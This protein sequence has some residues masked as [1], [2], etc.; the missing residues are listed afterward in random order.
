MGRSVDDIE[1]IDLSEAVRRRPAMYLGSID[2]DETMS[3]LVEQVL[4]SSLDEAFSGR[5]RHIAVSLSADGS[6][7]VEDD[8]A[9]LSLE[10][11]QRG[12][13]MAERLMTELGACRVQRENPDVGKRFCARGIA[14]VNAASESCK[15]EVRRDGRVWFQEY[16][17]GRV[18]APFRDLG[19]VSST[20]TRFWFKLDRKIL[21][22]PIDPGD[23]RRR[24]DEISLEVPQTEI[25]FTV[26]PQ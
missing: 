8:G 11:D 10:R 3:R 2:S 14:V 19:R 26:A 23:L 15:L 17:E 12:I 24:L 9:G 20:G 7:T 22:R 16:R 6:V 21:P 25:R 4:C 1:I 18:L 13:I 5:C